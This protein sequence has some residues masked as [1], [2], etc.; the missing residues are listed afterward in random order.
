MCQS[1]EEFEVKIID[2][3][4][5]GGKVLLVLLTQLIDVSSQRTIKIRPGAAIPYHI[6]MV[7]AKFSYLYAGESL[8]LQVHALHLG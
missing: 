3:S 2:H 1:S 4:R 6:G 5:G 8:R 7:K